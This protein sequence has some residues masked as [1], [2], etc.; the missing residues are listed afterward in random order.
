[1]REEIGIWAD[2]RPIGF[3]F[4]RRSAA[5]VGL[6]GMSMRFT[7]RAR[8]VMALA[9][10][11]AQ[12][13]EY[14]DT[15]H[16]LLGLVKEGTG[17][18]VRVLKN[19]GVGLSEVRAE[20]DKVVRQRPIIVATGNRPETLRAKRAIGYVLEEARNLNHNYVGTEH[21]LLGLIRNEDT[22]AAQVLMNL[23]LKPEE[24]RE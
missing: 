21:I 16:L 2:N 9:N 1:M 5:Q 7:D 18:G 20:L 11:E 8:K 6:T 4:T 24:L 3:P 15:G 12:T 14:I 19:F 17:V 13:D 10:Q 23:S 22:L